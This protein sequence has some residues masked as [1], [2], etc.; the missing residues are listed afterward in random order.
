M[1]SVLNYDKSGQS[2]G[3]NNSI[4]YV[5]GWYHQTGAAGLDA[6]SYLFPTV[7]FSGLDRWGNLRSSSGSAWGDS[8]APDSTWTI[9]IGPAPVMMVGSV[10]SSRGETKNSSFW[11]SDGWTVNQ[12][13]HVMMGLRYNLFSGKANTGLRIDNLGRLDPR[14]MVKWDPDG[15]GRNY[16]SFT[17]ARYSQEFAVKYFGSQGLS[18]SPYTNGYLVGWKGISGQSALPWP[19]P[20]TDITNPGG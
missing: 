14:L 9:P 6:S 19:Y 4:V 12:H 5:G 17:L 11:L 3:A 10:S 13:L 7:I 15:N 16:F 8:W 2:L 18:A 1:E 20:T